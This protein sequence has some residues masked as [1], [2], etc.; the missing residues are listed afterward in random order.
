MKIL[1]ICWTTLENKIT[2]WKKWPSRLRVKDIDK[3]DSQPQKEQQSATHVDTV[4][5]VQFEWNMVH[6]CHW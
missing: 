3:T 1:Q 6:Y 5:G 2:F 4:L